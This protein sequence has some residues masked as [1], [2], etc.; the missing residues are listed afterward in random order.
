MS[1]KATKANMIRKRCGE[2]GTTCFHNPLIEKGKFNGGYRCT[3]C[4]Y[5]L[6]TGPKR[7]K[8]SMRHLQQVAKVRL[9]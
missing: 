3:Y 1:E 5:P 4:G 8:T 9:A 7:D 6:G 2:C